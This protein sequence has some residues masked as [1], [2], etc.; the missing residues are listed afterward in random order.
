LKL[1]NCNIQDSGFY[2]ALER[3]EK[4]ST[5]MTRIYIVLVNENKIEKEKY[6]ALGC[7][8]GLRAPINDDV[9]EIVYVAP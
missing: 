9:I 4:S 3:K 5:D 7:D 8:D 2:V 1:H 6:V